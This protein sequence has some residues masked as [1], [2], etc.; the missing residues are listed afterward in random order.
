MV[1]SFFKKL[2]LFNIKIDG[3][4]MCFLDKL[5]GDGIAVLKIKVRFA[6]RDKAKEEVIFNILTLRFYHGY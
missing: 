1:L 2:T 5:G 3:V 6:V 4:K